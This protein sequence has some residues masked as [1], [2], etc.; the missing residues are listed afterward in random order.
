MAEADRISSL[1][2]EVIAS[3][4]SRLPLEDAVRTS[5]LARSWRHLWTFSPRLRLGWS[6]NG[7]DDDNDGPV[8]SSWIERVHHVVASVRGPLLH[9]ALSQRFS[10]DQAALLQRLLDLLHSKGCLETLDLSIS[11]TDLLFDRVVIHLPSFHSLMKLELHGC[12]IVLPTDFQ[13]FDRLSTLS[14]DSV[15]IS[16]SEYQ[17]LSIKLSLPLLRYLEILINESVEKVEVVSALCLEQASIWNYTNSDLEKFSSVTLGL[18]TSIAVTVSS[19]NLEFDVLQFLS[20]ASLPSNFTFPRV[21]RLKLFVNV[22]TMD[23]KTYDAVIWLLRS[24]PFLEV[25]DIQLGYYSI[26][27]NRVDILMRDLFLKRHDGLSCLDQTLERVRVVTE[28]LNIVL[29]GITLVKFFL[30]NARVLKLMKVAYGTGSEVE[31][32]M[33]EELQKGKLTTSSKAKVVMV[34]SCKYY[35]Y[36]PSPLP[37]SF[38]LI[39]N[40]KTSK[41][42]QKSKPLWWRC[43]TPPPT[44]VSP[45]R[46]RPNKCGTPFCANLKLPKWRRSYQVHI[47]FEFTLI[48]NMRK[49]PLHRTNMISFAIFF[50][51]F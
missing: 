8:A 5:V 34:L 38:I 24:I 23:K 3:I 12:R 51:I 44:P 26:G 15:G 28:N 11:S 9:F 32:S 17:P 16:N 27:T 40:R 49:S 20:L 21:I 45:L 30:L 2:S 4:L 46:V 48:S 31:P 1:P 10:S 19:L 6:G 37:P 36:S 50:S 22:R 47:A 42:S 39:A 14:L 25:L 41:I 43:G 33:I 18:L 29:T 7:S 13:G 35:L